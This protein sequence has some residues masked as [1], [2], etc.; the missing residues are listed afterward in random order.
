[1]K[2]IH[3]DDLDILTYLQKA[4]CLDLSGFSSNPGELCPRLEEETDQARAAFLAYLELDLSVRSLPLLSGM[5][6]KSLSLLKRWS[7]R[8]KWQERAN[9][10]DMATIRAD[11][12][13]RAIAR[14][15]REQEAHRESRASWRRQSEESYQKRL[16]GIARKKELGTL[17]PASLP[18]RERSGYVARFPQWAEELRRVESLCREA[19]KRGKRRY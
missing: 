11:S 18:K 17:H 5:L 9:A 7:A 3:P 8:H 12:A 16:A 19:S 14:V 15:L 13:T 6:G 10:Y 4:G 1:M 2:D